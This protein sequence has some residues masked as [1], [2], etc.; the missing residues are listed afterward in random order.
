MP[1][2]VVLLIVV[3]LAELWLILEVADRIGVAAT[4]LTLLGVSIVGGWLLKREGVSTWRRFRAT[5]ARGEIPTNEVVDGTL[6]LMGGA[7]LLTPGFLTDFVGLAF[8][9][10]P[11][12][13]A[14][15]RY[16]RVAVRWG[17]FKRFGFKSEAARQVY[18]TSAR[19][20]R[21]KRTTSP[22]PPHPELSPSPGRPDDADDSPGKG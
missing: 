12:R 6:I 19:R 10:P 4:V 20:V 14:I 15:R 16:A 8:V 5:M 1:V 3:P 9:L 17:A 7:L 21:A 2:L 22:S 18:E 11:S 13:A